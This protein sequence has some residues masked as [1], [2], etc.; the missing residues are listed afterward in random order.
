[1]KIFEILNNSTNALKK[2]EVENP[3]TDARLLLAHA[4]NKD[5]SYIIGHSDEELKE[6]E[7]SKYNQLVERRAKREPLSHIIQKR[8]FWKYEFFVS[9]DVLDPRPDS[10]TL[11]ET[12]LELYKDKPPKN[13]LEFGVGSGCLILSLM[14]EFP[15]ATAVG[16]DISK[17]ALA[18]NTQS[19]NG[20]SGSPIVAI[21]P[22][23]ISSLSVLNRSE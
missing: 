5:V 7:I 3:A 10:E 23:I 1:M 19:S 17:K 22:F 21:M 16:V 11:I 4:I 18:I 2:A 6:E 14:K 15:N 9:G 8:A 13:M 12:V 20:V